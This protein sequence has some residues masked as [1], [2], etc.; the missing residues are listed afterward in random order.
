MSSFQFEKFQLENVRKLTRINHAHRTGLIDDL[1][2][3][4][5]LDDGRVRGAQ[6]SIELIDGQ[7]GQFERV[8]AVRLSVDQDTQEAGSKWVR[9]VDGQVSG[10]VRQVDWLGKWICQASE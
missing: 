3:R 7:S 10:L 6:L 4:L 1:D 5:Y 2:E 8:L 9:Q